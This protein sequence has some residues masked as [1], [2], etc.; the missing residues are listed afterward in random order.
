MNKKILIFLV[1]ASLSIFV[2]PTFGQEYI[3]STDMMK[4]ICIDE[5][6][7]MNNVKIERY[8]IDEFYNL[9]LK[10]KNTEAIKYIENKYPYIIN[11]YTTLC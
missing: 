9:M 10:E 11:G 6:Y 5:L 1:L 8:T 4:T 3:K 7:D 2:T